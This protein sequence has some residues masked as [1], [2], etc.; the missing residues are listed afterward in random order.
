MKILHVITSLRV[1]GAEKLMVD[2]L[3]NFKKLGNE[4]ELFLFDGIDTPFKEQLEKAGI[5]IHVSRVEGNVYN[6]INI[7]HLRKI[8]NNYDIVHTHNTAPQLFAVLARAFC[9]KKSFILVTTEHNT[10]NRR[11]GNLF[12]KPI[13]KWMYSQYSKI[14][15]ISKQAE[16]N[17][18]NYL[19]DDSS[20][21]HKEARVLRLFW[22]LRIVLFLFKLFDS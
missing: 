5:K 13:D 22:V 19:N 18:R 3:P 15:C 21:Y 9:I 20:K 10:T 12:F 14:I 7:L 17:L 4:V 1:G 16:T 2:L 6:P 11:R 8:I